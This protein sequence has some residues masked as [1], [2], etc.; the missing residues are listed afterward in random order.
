[1]YLGLEN[2]K[3]TDTQFWYLKLKPRSNFKTVDE[4]CFHCLPF[5]RKFSLRGHIKKINIR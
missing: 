5:G 3:A 2:G 1:M 4:K